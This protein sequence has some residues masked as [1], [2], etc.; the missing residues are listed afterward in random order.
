MI[1]DLATSDKNGASGMA[2]QSRGHATC[3][4]AGEGTGSTSRQ[5]FSHQRF[6]L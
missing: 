6:E 2:A 1:A 3:P 4:A 5:G